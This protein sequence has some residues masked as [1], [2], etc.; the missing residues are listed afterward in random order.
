MEGPHA[1]HSARSGGREHAKHL[2]EV[3][4]QTARETQGLA[5]PVSARVHPF[6]GKANH[7]RFYNPHVSLLPT[8]YEDE[9]RELDCYPGSSLDNYSACGAVVCRIFSLPSLLVSSDDQC[10]DLP[11]LCFVAGYGLN[12]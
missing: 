5:Y 4:A 7:A 9:Q 8:D 2:P 11:S 6:P 12:K 3:A 10:T 1:L